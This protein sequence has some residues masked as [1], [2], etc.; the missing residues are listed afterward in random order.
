MGGVKLEV[1]KLQAREDG[2]QAA[3]GLGQYETLPVRIT[4]LEHDCCAYCFGLHALRV[5]AAAAHRK[6]CKLRHWATAPYDNFCV[7][8]DMV[9]SSIGYRSEA[10]E[11]VAFD[12]RGGVVMHR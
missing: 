10:I 1:N 8:A 4:I 3:V 11:G 9:L 6:S 7:Q 5:R 12:A 2:S